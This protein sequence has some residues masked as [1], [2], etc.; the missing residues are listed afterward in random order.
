MPLFWLVNEI[1]A[2]RFPGSQG[3]LGPFRDQTALLF[4]QRGV[5]V[6]QERVGIA[7]QLG[8]DKKEPRRSDRKRKATLLLDPP[9][10][11]WAGSQ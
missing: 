4:S 7:S 2:G 8:D 10:P 11:T 1:G 3:C 5:Q 6:E 9:I